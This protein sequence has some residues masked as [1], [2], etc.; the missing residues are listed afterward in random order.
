LTLAGA[1]KGI[2]YQRL[3]PTADGGRIHGVEIMVNTGRI[4]ERIAD[5]DKTSQIHD[6]IG[7]GR[8]YGM[9]RS[10]SRWSRS[11][12]RGRPTRRPHSRHPHRLTTSS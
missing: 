6:L 1:L 5:P 2:V 11:S 10:T 9:S 8:F 7:E 12:C 4:A 3:V